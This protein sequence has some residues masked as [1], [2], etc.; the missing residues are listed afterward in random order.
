MTETRKVIVNGIEF[1]VLLDGEGTSWSATVE[2]QTF[3][4]EIP[5]AAPV[6]KKKR[7]GS[8]KKKKSGTVSA[9]IPGKVVTVEVKAG[10]EVVE[11]Q[12]IL[13]LEAMKMQNEIQAPVSGTVTSVNCEEGQ[14]IEANIPLVIIEPAPE[15]E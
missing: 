5:D 3:E 13:I 12:V 7:S 14:A 2:G 1:E 6:A 15:A 8:G 4:I 9:N 10:D 11:G